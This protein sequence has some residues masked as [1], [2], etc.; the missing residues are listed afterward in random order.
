MTLGAV[1]LVLAGLLTLAA[2]ILNWEWFFKYTN[3]R[4][5]VSWFG[6]DGARIAYGTIGLVLVMV[7]ILIAT[8]VITR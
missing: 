5:F 7:G 4:R 3:A 2:S 6:K 8:G 1:I